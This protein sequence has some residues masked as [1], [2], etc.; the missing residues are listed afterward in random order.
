[1]ADPSSVAREQLGP[2]EH[3]LWSGQ[4]KTGVRLRPADLLMVPFSL[5]WG[6][7]AIF[8]EWS[9]VTSG[10]PLFFMLWGIPFVLTGLYLIVGRFFWDAY[11][12]SQT[13]YGLTN[14]RVFIVMK[15]VGGTIKS[16]PLRT[17]TDVTLAASRDGSG[18]IQFGSGHTGSPGWAAGS[19]WPGMQA[20]APAFEMLENARSTYDLVR[21]AQGK[22]S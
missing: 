16:L 3:L 7:F 2:D 6:G 4:P 21:Q 8:W 9:V 15:G 17:L 1:M 12:R 13:Y 18:S 20:A 11:R 5:M 22:A 10:A 14:Q 19:G